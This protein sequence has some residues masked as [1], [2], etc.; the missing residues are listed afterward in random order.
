VSKGPS[1][2]SGQAIVIAGV[3]R[4]GFEFE[5]ISTGETFMIKGGKKYENRYFIVNPGRYYLKSID[6]V[7]SNSDNLS[8]DKPENSDHSFLVKEGYVTYLGEWLID[9]NQKIRHELNWTIK[10]DYSTKYL[11]K[12]KKRN[13]SLSKLPLVISNEE[14]KT[15]SISWEKI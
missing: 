2:E 1:L 5:E 9:T 7:F 4:H 12:M 13:K 8:F 6:P 11:K 15:V 3:E 10:R 14:G